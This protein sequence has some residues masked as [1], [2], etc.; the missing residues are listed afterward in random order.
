[1]LPGTRKT[2][3][4]KNAQEQP[5][6]IT[7]TYIPRFV[8]PSD[9]RVDHSGGGVG[10]S[11]AGDAGHQVGEGLAGVGRVRALGVRVS[12]ALPSV[13]G[14][15]R[16]L[17]GEEVMNRTSANAGKVLKV[18]IYEPV[19]TGQFLKSL[20]ALSIVKFIVF[21]LDRWST[22]LALPQPLFPST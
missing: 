19:N 4:S 8:S 5:K 11:R 16:D 2:C 18:C 10:C 3:Y 13:E 22:F 12:D 9:E 7:W 17:F 21:L 1:M 15:V 20:V 14:E 6:P